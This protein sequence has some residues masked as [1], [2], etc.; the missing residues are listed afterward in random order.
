VS[1]L[2]LVED[3]DVN[4]GMETRML[5]KLGYDVDAVAHGAEALVAL[6]KSDYHAVLLDV[7]MPVMDGVTTAREI[8]ASG[9]SDLPIIALTAH[10]FATDRERCL[11]AGMN[12][13]LAKPVTIRVLGEMVGRWIGP[14]GDMPR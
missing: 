4:R 1:R 12:D 8:R 3:N 2:L 6:E 11:A 13:Y 14:S 9:R 10:A 7:Q 5:Q